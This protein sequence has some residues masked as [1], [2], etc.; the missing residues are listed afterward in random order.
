MIPKRIQSHPHTWQWT[1]INIPER[2]PPGSGQPSNFTYGDPLYS[3][4]RRL[5]FVSRGSLDPLQP[6][7]LR[8]ASPADPE[9]LRLLAPLGIC[10]QSP[11]PA[12]RP[13]GSA[14]AHASAPAAAALTGEEVGPTS[15]TSDSSALE[16]RASNEVGG[17]TLGD[18]DPL[19]GWDPILFDC[20]VK[21][22]AC[23]APAKFPMFLGSFKPSQNPSLRQGA[24]TSAS[25]A[26]RP[27][28]R[29]LHRNTSK[30][31]AQGEKAEP[32]EAQ[33]LGHR[34]PEHTNAFT[35]SQANEH[36]LAPT[37]LADLHDVLKPERLLAALMQ[38]ASFR[39]GPEQLQKAGG[40]GTNTLT[41][42]QIN[43][44]TNH[45]LPPSTNEITNELTT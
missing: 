4:L 13:A 5:S 34:Q 20:F 1:A 8:W 2:P 42:K 23:G 40:E 36:G 30:K 35:S 25:P 21:A 14:A 27:P 10:W 17:I 16:V 43:L 15:Q 39:S 12:S 33:V 19:V 32:R 28:T 7:K 37:W 45:Q 11:A 44:Q 3:L 41:A 31:E 18:G 6:L 24:S 29:R 38:D 26:T 22:A 9:E